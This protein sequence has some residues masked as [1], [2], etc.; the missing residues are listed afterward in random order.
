MTFFIIFALFLSAAEAYAPDKLL[1]R[2]TSWGIDPDKHLASINLKNSWQKFTKK[3]D[4]VV[5]VV[6]TGIQFDHPFLKDNIYVP[7]GNVSGSNYGFDFAYPKADLMPDDEHGHG[8]HIAGIIKSIFPE[9]KILSLKYYDPKASGEAHLTATIKALRKAVDLNVDIINYSGGGPA[10]SSEEL[11]I[12]KEA[13]QKGIL[14]IAAAGNK[15]SNIDDRRNAFFPA[16]YQLPNIITVGSHDELLRLVPSSNF[17]KTSVEIVAPGSQIRSAIPNDRSAYMTGT[18]QATAFVTGVAAMIMANNPDLKFA[19]VKQ[20]ILASALKVKSFEG[21]IQGS[22]KLD[23][24]KA[25][26]MAQE[27]Q[28]PTRNVANRR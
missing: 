20:I 16:S 24:E 3:K 4:I 15:A 25:L 10:S 23:A 7:E 12:L 2:F 6:D 28:N 18:S 22:R 26:T 13:H 27:L 8:T 19:T 9:V 21:K 17:G 11:K 1:S 14:V 5:A